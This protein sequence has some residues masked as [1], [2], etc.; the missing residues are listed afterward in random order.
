M[1]RLIIVFILLFP[2]NGIFSGLAHTVSMVE[3]HTS[4][5]LYDRGDFSFCADE[6]AFVEECEE[7]EEAVLFTS[8]CELRRHEESVVSAESRHWEDVGVLQINAL[9]YTNLPPPVTFH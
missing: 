9:F 1:S 8:E 6:P 2:I 7:N 4:S 5:L 3:A